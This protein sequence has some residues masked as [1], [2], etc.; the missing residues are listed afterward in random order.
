VVIHDLD[1]LRAGGRPTKAHSKLIVAANA[2][3]PCAVSLER[4][5]SVTG[6]HAQVIKSACDLQLADLATRN[7]LNAREPPH[8][9]PASECF[10]V[11]VPE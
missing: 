3:L 9:T 10:S 7:C 8:A 1:I 6:R 5:Q 4:L 2:V 11:A